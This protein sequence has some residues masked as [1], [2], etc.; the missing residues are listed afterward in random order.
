M[1]LT[2]S[3]GGPDAASFGIVRDTGQLQT[4]A[5][6]D[7]ETKDTY[8]VTV[9]AADSLS[10]SSTITVTIKVT[11][12]DEMPALEGE[13]PEEYAEK[14]TSATWRPLRQRTRRASRSLGLWPPAADMPKTS[15]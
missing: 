11:N 10:E 8:T 13:A 5:E 6:L 4:K 3:L 1:V 2:Y 12:V 14:G 9:T 7:K 15:P